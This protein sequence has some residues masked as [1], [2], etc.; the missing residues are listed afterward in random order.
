MRSATHINVPPPTANQPLSL[1]VP[2]STQQPSQPLQLLPVPIN[3]F[4]H[5][6]S[7][8]H[9][10][11]TEK[12]EEEH[13]SLLETNLEPILFFYRASM[14]LERILNKQK[15]EQEAQEKS[16]L[17]EKLEKE[18]KTKQQMIEN[19]K[20][21]IRENEKQL[22]AYGPIELLQN[23]LTLVQSRKIIQS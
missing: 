4:Q 14:E 23:W 19:L 5:N 16:V 11:T 13:V 8:T 21:S 10:T 9:N 1:N 15:Y 6:P 2:H 20:V 22:E 12:E 3:H 18:V 17:I 7:F